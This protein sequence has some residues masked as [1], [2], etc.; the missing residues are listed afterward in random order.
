MSDAIFHICTL[1]TEEEQD[2][3]YIASLLSFVTSTSG[4]HFSQFQIIPYTYG[5][6]THPGNMIFCPWPRSRSSSPHKVIGRRLLEPTMFHPLQAAD[7]Q[8]PELLGIVHLWL[9][10]PGIAK[11]GTR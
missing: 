10:L 7:C 4:A 1:T 9:L 2:L 3:F 6:N 11:D 8:L 5:M